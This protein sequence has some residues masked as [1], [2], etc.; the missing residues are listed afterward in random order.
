MRELTCYE[1]AELRKREPSKFLRFLYESIAVEYFRKRK[2]LSK[3]AVFHLTKGE[4]KALSL[5]KI[6][7]KPRSYDKTKFT[8]F[9]GFINYCKHQLDY[10]FR[11]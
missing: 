4:T 5:L 3:I 7:V 1:I 11:D 6:Q 9:E 10:D 8:S 2:K